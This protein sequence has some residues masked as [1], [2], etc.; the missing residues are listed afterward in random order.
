MGF[1][2]L[3]G[4]NKPIVS[5]QRPEPKPGRIWFD[6]SPAHGTDWYVAENNS[7]WTLIAGTPED[8]ANVDVSETDVAV[9]HVGDD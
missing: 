7:E 6:T 1:E 5:E 9:A 4:S 3:G 2:P 8:G